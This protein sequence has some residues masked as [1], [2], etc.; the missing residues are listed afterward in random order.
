VWKIGAY[1]LTIQKKFLKRQNIKEEKTEAIRL[2]H[3]EFVLNNVPEI[4]PVR[5]PQIDITTVSTLIQVLI[6]AA[7]S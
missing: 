3:P 4:V 6:K 2:W 1:F 5:L 7:A